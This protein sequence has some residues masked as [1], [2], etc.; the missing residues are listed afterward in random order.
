MSHLRN[1]LESVEL[2]VEKLRRT[3][4]K[5][6]LAE[7]KSENHTYHFLSNGIIHKESVPQDKTVNVDY[8]LSVMK[9]LLARIG[10]SLIS[11]TRQ[12]VVS[13]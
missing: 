3:N 7:I 10:S 1:V 5:K 8:Y 4:T 12:L 9:H 13:A 2:S 6:V 11:N